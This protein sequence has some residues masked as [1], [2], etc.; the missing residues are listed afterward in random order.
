MSEIKHYRIPKNCFDMEYATQWKRE[1]EYLYTRGIKPTFTKRDKEYGVVT[2]KYK[3]TKELFAALAVLYD[4]IETE[5][6]ITEIS[7]I[8]S[9]K[10]N[11]VV[12]TVSEEQADVIAGLVNGFTEGNA[13]DK[14]HIMEVLDLAKQMTEI[15]AKEAI[16]E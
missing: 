6:G 12:Y 10:T 8:F 16:E 4:T 15:K 2:Y 14:D 1:V 7:E 13:F 3:K 11:V 9:G 5:K